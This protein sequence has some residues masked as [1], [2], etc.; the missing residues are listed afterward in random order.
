MIRSEDQ[1]FGGINSNP[2]PQRGMMYPAVRSFRF[3]VFVW[4][5]PAAA[6][7]ERAAAFGGAAAYLQANGRPEGLPVT[8]V[9][10]SGPHN[11]HTHTIPNETWR[12]RRRIALFATQNPPPAPRGGGGGVSAVA[13]R[14]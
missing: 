6:P 2:N 1:L 12:R 4:I 3:H 7:A 8:I 10:A 9:K 5:G 14:G 13:P 11:T